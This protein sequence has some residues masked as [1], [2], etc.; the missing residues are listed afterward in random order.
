MNLSKRSVLCAIQT[1]AAV[2]CP[3]LQCA[4]LAFQMPLPDVIIMYGNYNGQTKMNALD[5]H[6]WITQEASFKSLPV[7]IPRGNEGN[8]L[9]ET[10]GKDILSGMKIKIWS[11]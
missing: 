4:V 3:A 9:L 6:W 10:V 11:S 8:Q 7:I 2:Q 1:G 5:V